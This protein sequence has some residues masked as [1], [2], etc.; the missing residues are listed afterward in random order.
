MDLVI[1]RQCAFPVNPDNQRKQQKEPFVS[2]GRRAEREEI[3]SYILHL[4]EKKKRKI[5]KPAR[6]QHLFTSV[7]CD[8][9][10]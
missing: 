4:G 9:A 2:L 5:K 8:E 6:G 10:A 1:F 7:D 3:Y